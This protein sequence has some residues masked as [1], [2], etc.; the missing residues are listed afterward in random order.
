MR[1]PAHEEHLAA[2]FG[3]E[4][5]RAQ[6]RVARYALRTLAAARLGMAP[7]LVPLAVEPGG[8]PFLREREDV[9]VSLAHSAGSRGARALAAVAGR[10]VGVDLERLRPVA[11]RLAERLL[12]PG[13]AEL[14]GQVSGALGLPADAALLAAWVLKEAVL[15]G[16][17]TGLRGGLRAVRLC[18]A[19]E[20]LRAE[21]LAHRWALRAALRDGFVCALAWA[22]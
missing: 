6:F 3:S 5:R 4:A 1:L 8:A 14:L 22:H 2:T 16:E 21:G 11:P 10:P 17:R 19:P 18:G 15:K 9:F 12:V 7:H 20:A 13:E